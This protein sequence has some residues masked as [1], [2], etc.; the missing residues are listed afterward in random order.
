MKKYSQQSDV[1]GHI[2]DGFLKTLAKPNSIRKVA[3]N[4]SVIKSTIH[5]I[6]YIYIYLKEKSHIYI[7]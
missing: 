1:E 2:Y 6:S 5:R 7:I 3:I 4:T